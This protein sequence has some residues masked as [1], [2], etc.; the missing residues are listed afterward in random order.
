MRTDQGTEQML[1][2]PPQPFTLVIKLDAWN[3]RERDDWGQSAQ[4]RAAGQ[5]PQRWHWVYGGTC[6]G[7]DQRVESDGAR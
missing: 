6:F 7:L 1:P 2:R 3:I 4:K 5:E